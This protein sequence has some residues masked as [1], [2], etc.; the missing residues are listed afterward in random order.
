MFS[1]IK[2]TGFGPV[3]TSQSPYARLKTLEF[4]D[5]SLNEGFWAKKINVNRKISL[6]FGFEML[7]KAGNFDNLRI[8]AG[9]IK[10]NYRGYVFLDS[11]IYKW[12]EAVAWEMGRH[13]DQELSSKADQAIALI[14]AAQWP[15]GYINSYVQTR[16][17]PEPWKDLDNGHELYCA[18]H[19]FQAA[20]A[21][22]RALG[23]QRL[24]KIACG[25]ADQICSVFGPDKRHGACG[26][27][28]VEMAL[29]EL[30]RVTGETRYLDLAKFF[31]DQRGQNVMKGHRSYG[32]EYHQ[33]HIQVREITEAAGHAVRQ[34]YLASGVTDLFLET[35]EQVLLDSMLRLS[36]D[37]I[38]TKLYITGGMGARFD[39]EAFGDPYELPTDQCY[40]E[41]CA[42]IAS[43]MWN[44]RM[45]LSSGE[46]CYADQMEQALYNNILASPALDGQHYFYINPLMLR[47]ARFL[48]LSTDLPPSKVFIPDQRPEWHDCACCPPNVM[49][50]F[51]SF[52]HYLATHDAKGIQIHHFAP[53]DIECELTKGL[54]IKLNITTE[55]PWQGNIKFRVVE[56][57]NLPWVLSI[58]NP[59]WSQ[60]P[61]VSIN[62]KT[63]GDLNQEKG[64]LLL[65]R[66]WQVDDI[67]EL[68]LKMETMLVASNPRIDAT[69]GCLAIQRGPLVYCLED[70]DQ[71]IK[72]R[73]LD[74]EID[75]GQSLLTRWESDLLDGVMLVEAYGQFIDSEAWRGYLYQPATSALPG[76]SS[77]TRL[78][79][80]PYY[81]WGNRG[82]GGMRVWI[83]KKTA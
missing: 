50:L 26:H 63:L 52:S 73:L 75:Q 6:H 46:G 36:K 38:E 17:S 15:N 61:R 7:Q 43:L 9:L 33:D 58:R 79:A 67:V 60:T 44:W 62:G 41:T 21:F 69:R 27:P 18:G 78:V 34:L 49:R 57:G 83:P 3:N 42:A 24:L 25:F 8:A 12:L 10:G 66:E 5:I 59:E 35:G 81:A 82:I 40:C 31:I 29:V 56:T 14:A 72:G 80:I 70:Q 4:R 37:I 20:V 22:E 48:R 71:G 76:K 19:L 39:G 54:W 2:N 28:E 51:S 47:E 11:D 30:F 32:P 74:V 23:D 16:E 64:Y 1:K 55:Y 53:A 65:E 45:L 13:P 77:S 68:E